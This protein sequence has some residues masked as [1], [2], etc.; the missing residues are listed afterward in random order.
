[1]KQKADYQTKTP[2]HIGECGHCHAPWSGHDGGKAFPGVESHST[3]MSGGSG[4]FCLCEMCWSTMTPEQR[5]PF[6]R[7]LW[8][9]WVN[10]GIERPWDICEWDQLR[11][12]VLAEVDE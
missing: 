6:Y 4:C 2:A 3:P 12:A 7:A 9:S 8:I 11:K 5:L 10:S 1:M